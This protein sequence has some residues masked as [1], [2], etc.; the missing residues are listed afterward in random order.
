MDHS[1]GATR[2]LTHIFHR[3]QEN[4]NE[5]HHQES[6]YQKLHNQ[7]SNHIVVELSVPKHVAKYD[8]LNQGLLSVHKQIQ[9]YRDLC[10]QRQNVIFNDSAGH[11]LNH[12]IESQKSTILKV[13][14]LL[15]R[16]I[17]Y[18]LQ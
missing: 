3:H 15:I 18:I 1:L 9:T 4:H 10:H 7:E 17:T 5:S 12:R 2:D 8:I 6:D 14:L 13:F 11:E 16:Y